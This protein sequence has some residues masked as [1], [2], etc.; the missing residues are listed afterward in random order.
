ML[1]VIKSLHEKKIY[2]NLKKDIHRSVQVFSLYINHVLNICFRNVSPTELENIDNIK[3]LADISA[4]SALL[5]KT[6]R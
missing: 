1:R 4:P 5:L 3:T 6:D 2:S